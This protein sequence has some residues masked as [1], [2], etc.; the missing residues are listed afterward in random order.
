MARMIIELASEVNRT[1]SAALFRFHKSW[2]AA[3]GFE[4]NATPLALSRQQT[5]RRTETR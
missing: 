3:P 5:E 4:V 1:F 2:G